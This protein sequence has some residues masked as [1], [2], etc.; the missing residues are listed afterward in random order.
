MVIL[1]L[2]TLLNDLWKKKS[3]SLPIQWTPIAL[4]SLSKVFDYTF[5]EFGEKQLRILSDKIT[6]AANRIATFPQIGKVEESLSRRLNIEYR[7]ISVIHEINLIYTIHNDV[8]FIEY[9]KNNRQDDA[10]ILSY[11]TSYISQDNR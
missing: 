8:L 7:S 2:W 9:V 3:M 6:T 1:Y 10:T 4:Q 5:E 11:L